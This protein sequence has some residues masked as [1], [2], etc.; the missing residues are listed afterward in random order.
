MS[1][2]QFKLPDIGEGISEGTVEKWYVKP[3]DQLKEDAELIEIEN[4]K[5]V[6][7][8]TSSVTGTVKQILVA[9]GQTAIVGQALVELEVAGKSSINEAAASV[10]AS[11]TATP[12]IKQ[13]SNSS[14]MV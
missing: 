8:L 7:E 5:S 14:L 11:E 1:T 4:D 12:N 6:E 9:E 13:G 2:Y 10:E 3:G